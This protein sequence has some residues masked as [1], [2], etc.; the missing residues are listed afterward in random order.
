[1]LIK[2]KDGFWLDL[3]KIMGIYKRDIDNEEVY[4]ILLEAG[5]MIKSLECTAEE[6]LL[7][8]KKLREFFEEQQWLN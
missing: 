4:F 5:D 7:V 2:L 3:S 6:G 8:E 1:M